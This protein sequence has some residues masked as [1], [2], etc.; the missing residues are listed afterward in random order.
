MALIRSLSS[1]ERDLAWDPFLGDDAMAERPLWQFERPAKFAGTAKENAV[2]WMDR[3]E[4]IGRHNRWTQND[5]ATIVDVYFEGTAY[6]W[7]VG[8]EVLAIGR[9]VSSACS[10]GRLARAKEIGQFWD[11]SRCF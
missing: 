5:L 10:Q 4:R 2:E 7:I 9:T 1:E 11:L 3:F 8:L 6:K